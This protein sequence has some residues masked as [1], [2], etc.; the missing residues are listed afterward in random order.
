MQLGAWVAV[1]ALA[2]SAPASAA[3][4]TVTVDGL[5]SGLDTLGFFG[6]PG[7]ELTAVPFEAVYRFDTATPGASSFTYGMG[8]NGQGGAD[9]TGGPANSAEYISP[10]LGASLTINGHTVTDDGQYYGLLYAQ[11]S[12]Q[13]TANTSTYSEFGSEAYQAGTTTLNGV[14]AT[15]TYQL[16]TGVYDGVGGPFGPSGILPYTIDQGFTVDTTSDVATGQFEFHEY[17]IDPVIAAS[18]CQGMMA[19]CPYIKFDDIDLYS[20]TSITE[21]VESVP[22]PPTWAMLLLGLF[23]IGFMARN[24]R[25]KDAV[26]VI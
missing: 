14:A 5:G 18:G 20:I 22:E 9:I 15:Y 2:F 4:V 26:V 24:A 1:A 25:R 7:T 10:S 23:V 12:G 17:A 21:T 19:V 3:I 8:V 11:N 13:P 16:S 6:A